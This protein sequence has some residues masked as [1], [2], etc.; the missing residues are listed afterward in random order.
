[1]V[2]QFCSHILNALFLDSFLTLLVFAIIFLVGSTVFH[3][4]IP[5][6]LTLLVLD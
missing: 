5:S 1:M 6:E 4:G 3:Q 2:E